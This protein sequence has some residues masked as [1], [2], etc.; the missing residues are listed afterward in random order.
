[1][2]DRGDDDS[3]RRQARLIPIIL[4]IGL[5]IAGLQG[6]LS[7]A[8]GYALFVIATVT[9]VFG[10]I[11]LLI[12]ILT[13]A[14][15]TPTLRATFT[16]LLRIGGWT[17]VLAVAALS[18]FF[19]HET[20][21]GRIEGKWILFG[22][23]AL[24]AIV[25]LDWGIYRLVLA[26]NLPTWRRFGHLVT[27]DAMDPAAMRKTLVDDV[28]L[29][30]SLMSVSGFRWFKHTLILWGFAVMF[31]IEL[32]AVVVREALPAFGYADI[33]EVRD[34]P[35]RLAFDFAYELTGAMVLVGCILAL[36]HRVVVN[37]TEVQKYS[38][39]PTAAFLL[40]VVVTGFWLEGLRIA[41]MGIIPSDAYSFLGHAIARM[42]GAPTDSMATFY[43]AM[44]LIHVL[45][46]CAF[47]AYVPAKRLIH[48]C[49]VP[50]GRLMNSQK[51]LL[52]AKK[53]AV[54]RGMMGGK[55]T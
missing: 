13:R 22:P 34:H 2:D 31:G 12:F 54:I 14:F 15:H 18:G 8:T 47:I 51:G 45:A 36:I 32:G 35:L 33:W 43:E 40:F 1:M 27:R 55:S 44:W 23:A 21:Q 24:V 19:F 17:Y 16:G 5:L 37:G 41:L 38:D 42:Y 7:E 6:R 10:I 48:S 49:A 20:V 9:L 52:A 30:R 4:A 25:A 28:V 11:A 3:L 39:T 46:S 29:H 26:K 50:M 53:E